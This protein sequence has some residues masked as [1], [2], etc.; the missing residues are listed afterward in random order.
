MNRNVSTNQL[1]LLRAA[2]LIILSV[3]K[4]YQYINKDIDAYVYRYNVHRTDF[5]T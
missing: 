3:R 2:A 4:I 5:E 1:K